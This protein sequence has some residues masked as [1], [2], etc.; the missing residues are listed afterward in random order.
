[1]LKVTETTNS[2]LLTISQ[3]AQIETEIQISYSNHPRVLYTRELAFLIIL[4]VL[5]FL[6]R[7]CFSSLDIK[8]FIISDYTK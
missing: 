3:T 8:I 7:Q 1:M 6:M 2:L 5:L 4:Y